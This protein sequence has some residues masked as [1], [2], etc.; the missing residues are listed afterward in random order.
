MRA[1]DGGHGAAARAKSL[2]LSLMVSIR[3]RLFRGGY[4]YLPPRAVWNDPWR[5]RSAR[6]ERAEKGR[7]IRA[8]GRSAEVALLQ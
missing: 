5:K 8:L 7:R 6:R 1:I 2:V 3:S 4:P